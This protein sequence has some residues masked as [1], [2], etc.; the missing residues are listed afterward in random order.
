MIKDILF[1]SELTNS[2]NHSDNLFFERYG[3]EMRKKVV[4]L[5]KMRGN[6]TKKQ[7]VK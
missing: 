4:T 5:L 3:I 7:G 2:I 1:M 6:V